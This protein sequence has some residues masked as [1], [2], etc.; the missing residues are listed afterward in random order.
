MEP[1]LLLKQVIEI[2]QWEDEKEQ[3][4]KDNKEGL[5]NSTHEWAKVL[6]NVDEAN[7]ILSSCESGVWPQTGQYF[8]SLDL[9]WL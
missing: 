5:D 6:R 8:H 1:I 4:D 7:D 9:I 3:E 2:E